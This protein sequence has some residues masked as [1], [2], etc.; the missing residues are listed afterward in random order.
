MRSPSAVALIPLPIAIVYSA[1]ACAPNPRPDLTP[2]DLD[3]YGALLSTIASTGSPLLVEPHIRAL[4]DG[5][6]EALNS[7]SPISRLATRDLLVQG[8]LVVSLEGRLALPSGARY[9]SDT[10]L[11]PY[12]DTA[13]TGGHLIFKQ[14]LLSVS[15]IGFAMKNREA[16]V[17]TT[18][19]CGPLCGE[20]KVY[21]LRKEAAAW[22]VAD[23]IRIWV[24]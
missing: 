11:P 8:D 2:D 4:D 24:S 13:L 5:I 9:R 23:T 20:G 10:L 17:Y 6:L 19:H 18:L 7:L 12:L 22:A 16:V 1:V 21:F 3:V 15:R 14:G